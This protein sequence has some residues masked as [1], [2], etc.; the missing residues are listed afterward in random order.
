MWPEGCKD[1][2][3]VL[4]KY[5]KTVLSE[6]IAH[7]K[8]YPIAGTYDADN[9]TESIDRLYDSGVERGVSTGWGTIDPYYLVRPGAFTVVTGIPS[10]GKS[11][12]I[13]AMMV[14]IAKNH[15]WNFAIFSPENQPLEDHMARV[16]EKYIGEPFS[17][18][19]T[20]RMS[21]EDLNQGKHWLTKHFT[22]ILP[23]DDKEW[24]IDV[25]LDAAKRLVL[26]KGI[27]GLVIDPWN[28][29]EHMRDNNQTETEYISVALKR[30]RQFGRRY[31]IHIWVV[32]HPAKLYRDKSGKIPIPTP[33]DISGSA[34]WR[35]KSDNCI[36]IWRDLTKEEGCL[37]E[38]HVQK[39]RFRQDG[40]IGTGELTYNWRMGTYHLPLK[41]AEEIPPQFYNG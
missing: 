32:A 19:P 10:S 41:A 20:P 16:L 13:D 11:N 3:E 39:V 5:G 38:V 12:W 8:P 15:G 27:R 9:L 2:N 7:A 33:Y 21:K 28:E 35:D 22:W 31:G 6:C 26:T 23:S 40:K 34:R 4:V 30:I 37:I 24:S 14:N 29:L 36:T 1:S 25:I 17:N 18:G